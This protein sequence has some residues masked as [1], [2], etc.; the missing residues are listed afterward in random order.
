MGPVKSPRVELFKSIKSYAGDGLEMADHSVITLGR[1][2]AQSLLKSSRTEHFEVVGLYLGHSLEISNDSVC[3]WENFSAVTVEVFW[4]TDILKLV[5]LYL[6]DALKMAFC[7]VVTLGRETYCILTVEVT[8]N[9]EL[10]ES[11]RVI[12]GI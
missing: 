8:L 1:E 9:T 5:E 3:H 7:L 10:T 6:V 11:A 2:T 4:D 12:L